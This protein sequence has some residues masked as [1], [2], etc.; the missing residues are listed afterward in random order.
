MIAKMS[1]I[2]DLSYKKLDVE[3]GFHPSITSYTVTV[4]G[5]VVGSREG[6]GRPQLAA[7]Q[8]SVR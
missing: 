6:A 2:Q 8:T 5:G 3:H 7:S 1:H 4:Q